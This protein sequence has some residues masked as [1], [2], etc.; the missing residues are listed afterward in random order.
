[1]LEN[2][3]FNFESNV[4]KPF[5]NKNI[6]KGNLRWWGFTKVVGRNKHA[7]IPAML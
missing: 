4:A 3:F 7:L 5:F 6:L 1:V 2:E